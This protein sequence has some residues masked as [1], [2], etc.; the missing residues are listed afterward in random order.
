MLNA[1]GQLLG[2]VKA[3]TTEREF[4]RRDGLWDE[5][6]EKYNEKWKLRIFG[7]VVSVLSRFLF[8]S[9]VDCS[10]NVSRRG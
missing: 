1:G 4:C 3:F 8:N 7:S 5:R 6:E 9:M 2:L 10:R